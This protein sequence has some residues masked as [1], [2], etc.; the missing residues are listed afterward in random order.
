MDI[1]AWFEDY[2]LNLRVPVVREVTLLR[3]D[4]DVMFCARVN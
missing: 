4:Y 3:Y 2:T 1:A